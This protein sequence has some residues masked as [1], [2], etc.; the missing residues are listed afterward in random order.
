[1][2]SLAEDET[3]RDLY[4]KTFLNSKLLYYKNMLSVLNRISCLCFLFHK[5]FSTKM[6]QRIF[7]W[8]NIKLIEGISKKA[9][10]TILKDSVI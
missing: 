1:M 4:Y 7:M 8:Y 9:D 5:W 3:T 2:Q 10:K 6:E